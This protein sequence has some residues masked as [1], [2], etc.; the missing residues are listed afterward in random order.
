V[1]FLLLDGLPLGS[2]TPCWG[3]WMVS[4]NLAE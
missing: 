2:A 1:Y 4:Q 3:G